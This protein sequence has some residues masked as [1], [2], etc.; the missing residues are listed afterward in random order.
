[1]SKTWSIIRWNCE[2]LCMDAETHV[3]GPRNE[4]PM[5]VV[6][7]PYATPVAKPGSPVAA[8]VWITLAG[9][10][11]IA[12]GGC[13]LIGVMICSLNPNAATSPPGM[14][15]IILL[16]ALAILCFI[17][18]IWLMVLGIRKLLAVGR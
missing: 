7:L 14:G 4:T 10:G 8:G 18:A 11:L 5:S 13:F 12:L 15:F 6:S 9:L 1:V 2:G 3:P 16:Y 17:A